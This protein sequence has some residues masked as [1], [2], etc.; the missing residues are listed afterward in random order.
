ME[1]YDKFID[2]YCN[3][4]VFILGAGVSLYNI[5]KHPNFSDIFSHINISVNSSISILPWEDGN[6]EKRHWI[7]NDSATRLWDYWEKV[8]SSKANK[9]IRT[10]WEKYYNQIPSD[11]YIFDVRKDNV[12]LDFQEKKLVGCSSVPTAIDFALQAGCSKIFLLGV[13]HYFYNNKSHFW[14]FLPLKD[15]PTTKGFKAT[16]PMQSR[17]FA[18]NQKIYHNLKG[19][20]DYKKATVYNCNP[21]SAVKAFDKITFDDAIKTV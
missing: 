21:N 3:Q 1:Y 7:S 6:C 4:S 11:F 19:F 2:A 17:I 10:S 9:I 18:I 13:D 8:K 5:Y 14:Q 20:A 12:P 16:L 15:Q